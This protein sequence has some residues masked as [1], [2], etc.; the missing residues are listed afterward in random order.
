MLLIAIFFYMIYEYFI[1]LCCF[2]V[3]ERECSIDDVLLV[4][5]D[6]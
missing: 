5:A 4:A 1:M 6:N 3:T 2:H